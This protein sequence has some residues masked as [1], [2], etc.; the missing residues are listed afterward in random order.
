[1][2]R[3][4]AIGVLLA[5]AMATSGCVQMVT[6]DTV[7]FEAE[8]AS[9]NGEVL[10]ANDYKLNDRN[11]VTVNRTVEVPVV[12]ERDVEITNH[13]RAYSQAGGESEAE[14]T[15]AKPVVMFV[16]STPQAKVLGQAANPLG[17]MPLKEL[18]TQVGSRAGS[19]DDLEQVG[20]EDVDTLGTTTTVE[21]YSTT[22]ERDG[23]S[24]ETFVYVTRVPHGE[25][26]VITVA[27]V[28]EMFSE[29]ESAI[30]ELVGGLE[31]DDG[32]DG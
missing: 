10:S 29:E 26:Y 22:V 24:A 21:Q 1:M 27:M 30:Y 18:V 3:R 8:P 11:E 4:L 9:V 17:R 16:V 14:G 19:F 2:D 7:T 25:D 15:D 13:V 31:H 12:G 28:P 5:L 32:S 6:G 20:T 23:V